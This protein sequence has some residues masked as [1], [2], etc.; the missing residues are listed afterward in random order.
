[1]KRLSE[2]RKVQRFGKSTLMVS[3]P[4]EWVKVMGLKPGDL[5]R[6]NVREDGTL[7][8]VPH[9]STVHREESI[10]EILI[11]SKTSDELLRRA[12]YT[13]YITGHDKIVIRSVDPSLTADQVQGVRSMVRALI[14]AEIV[15]QDLSKIVVQVFIDTARYNIQNLVSRMINIIK[16]MISYLN[17]GLHEFK[18]SLFRELLELEFELDRVYTL[19]VRYTYVLSSQR[20]QES[21]EE[22]PLLT[23]YRALIKSL[24][25]VGDT[26]SSIAKLVDGDST[27][28]KLARILREPIAE[29]SDLINYSLDVMMASL[30]SR[31]VLLANK[32]VD[33][34]AEL[35][36]YFSKLEYSVVKKVGMEEYPKVRSMLERIRLACN[37]L[38][39]SAEMI[40]DIVVAS[41]GNRIDLT[42]K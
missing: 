23:E 9:S 24:E 8:V 1:M 17:A 11:S 30:N 26:L 36:S 27:F 25:D 18:T 32:S 4:A 31:N 41:K 12:I 19:A 28:E 39:S 37:Y 7:V 33:I 20:E 3:L 21:A 15:E 13:S 40:F 42:M 38:Q 29:I 35:V 2:V 22:L 10:V 34:T 5:V 16:S 14:G 6:I